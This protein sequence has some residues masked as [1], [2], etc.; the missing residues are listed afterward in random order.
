M[1]MTTQ[2]MIEH[3]I[4]KMEETLYKPNELNEGYVNKTQ[5]IRINKIAKEIGRIT[6]EAIDVCQN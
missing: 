6:K 1:L 2:E 4:D 3:L 5:L